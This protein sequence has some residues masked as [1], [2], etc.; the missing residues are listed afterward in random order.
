MS[1]P[2][3]IQLELKANKKKLHLKLG[4]LVVP[5]QEPE[6]K[7]F[8]VAGFLPIGSYQNHD[9]DYQLKQLTRKGKIKCIALKQNEIKSYQL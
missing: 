7:P 2:E 1:V 5:V 3:Y 9:A 8:C 6:I 4:Q